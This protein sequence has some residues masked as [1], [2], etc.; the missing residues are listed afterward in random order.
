MRVVAGRTVGRKRSTALGGNIT[1][2]RE[3]KAMIGKDIWMT[4]YNPL[5]GPAISPLATFWVYNHSI[6]ATTLRPCPCDAQP[7]A[8]PPEFRQVDALPCTKHQF[9]IR[10]GD[11]NAVA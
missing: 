4:A 8:T 2:V 11:R 5:L 9:T 6:V 3:A 1:K 10:D 7:P